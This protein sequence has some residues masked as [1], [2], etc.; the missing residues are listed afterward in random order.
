MK[1]VTDWG[2][3]PSTR[4]YELALYAPSAHAWT[5]RAPQSIQV[6]G[7]ASQQMPVPLLGHPFGARE[8]TVERLPGAARFKHGIDMKHNFRHLLPVR[9]FRFRIQQS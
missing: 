7:A 5:A 8:V 9:A 6:R 3:F 4:K 2:C 1:C